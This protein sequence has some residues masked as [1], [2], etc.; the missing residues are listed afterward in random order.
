MR[1]PRRGPM[2]GSRV[3]GLW[4][5]T[6]CIQPRVEGRS[7][8]M[9]MPAQGGR[10]GPPPHP[11][12]HQHRVEVMVGVAPLQP[13]PA[14]LPIEG[15]WECCKTAA[16]GGGSGFPSPVH[17]ST[18]GRGGERGE[19]GGPRWPQRT[20]ARC[21]HTWVRARGTRPAPC[22]L[23][24]AALPPRLHECAD[25]EP[26]PSVGVV[27]RAGVP[28]VR[29]WLG[30]PR[31][32]R[33]RVP[34]S[35]HP[36][37][38]GQHRAGGRE[39]VL[40]CGEGPVAP[41]EVPDGAAVGDTHPVAQEPSASSSHPLTRSTRRWGA[42]ARPEAEGRRRVAPRHPAARPLLPG[43]QPAA[44]NRLRPATAPPVPGRWRE[45]AARGVR[46]VAPPHF[47]SCTR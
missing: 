14:P 35:V 3:R 22:T 4:P 2:H 32:G 16:L 37:D 15:L 43:P 42:L 47:A 30:R 46:Y 23:H 18:W 39:R 36:R 13:T 19:G 8:P 17:H 9:C 44:G 12:A 40:G 24:P 26:R 7:P 25:R 27:P 21:L 11:C 29:G 31:G 6:L 38:G 45:D 10:N 33:H 20:A 34:H 5:P 28:V 1:G 41:E